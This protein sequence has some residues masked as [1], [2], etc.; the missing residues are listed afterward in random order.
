MADMPGVIQLLTPAEP[1]KI[2]QL[3]NPIPHIHWLLVQ[4][5][6]L[7]KFEVSRDNAVEGV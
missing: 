5:L 2:I 4:G 7:G 6:N 1:Q 3:D